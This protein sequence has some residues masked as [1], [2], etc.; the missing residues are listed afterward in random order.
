VATEN[1][2]LLEKIITAKKRKTEKG[3]ERY[4][5][6]MHEKRWR[7]QDKIHEENKKIASRVLQQTATI[8]HKNVPSTPKQLRESPSRV[9]Q[10]TF[11][12]SRVKER[13][14]PKLVDMRS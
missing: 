14:L 2:I 5:L 10:K 3:Q 12:E 9:Q 6:A 7:E 11:Y 4:T 8:H 1:Q 13:K